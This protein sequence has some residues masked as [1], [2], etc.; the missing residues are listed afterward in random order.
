MILYFEFEDKRRKAEVI[1]PKNNN[2]NIIVHITDRE[3]SKD[4][5]TDLYFETRED[6]KTSF[7]VEDPTNKRLVALQEVLNRRLQE[8]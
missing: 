3:L 7:I 8:I 1:W 2:D 5:P 4:L 6:N